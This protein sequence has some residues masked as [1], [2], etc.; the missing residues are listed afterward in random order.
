MLTIFYI[1]G[2][3]LSPTIS[4]EFTVEMC[5]A[6]KN[7]EKYQQNLSSGGSRLFKVIDV[8]KSKKPV[9]SACYDMQSVPIC[10]RFYT[11]RANSSKITSSKG[12]PLFDALV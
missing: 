9:T 6:A 2:L 3:G 11:T 7:C 5:A 10:N 4:S 12:V 8:E 1:G